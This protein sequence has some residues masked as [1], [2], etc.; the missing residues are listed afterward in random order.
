MPTMLR[1]ITLLLVLSLPTTKLVA[2]D[3]GFKIAK[4]GY[5]FSFPRDHGSHP[6]F[7]TEWWYYT[8]HLKTASGKDL[9][10]EV[11]FFRVGLR[12]EDAAAPQKSAWTMRNVSL[13]H[14]AITDIGKQKFRFYEK[15]NRSTPFTADSATGRLDV[16]NEQWNVRSQPDGS[17]RLIAAASGDSIDLNLRSLKPPAIHGENGISIKAEGIG[18]ASHYYSLTRMQVKGSVTTSGKPENVTG[19]AWMDHEFGS[20]VLRENQTGWDWFSLQ[21]NDGREL[22]LYIIRS[23]DGSPD[24]TSSGSLI[25]RD[26]K[27]RHLRRGEFL[28]S[29]TGKWKSAKS[30][31]TYP[32]GWTISVP[33]EQLQLTV[34]DRMKA[35]ELITTSSTQITYWEGAVSV[36]GTSRG[37]PLA[38][39]GYVEMTGYAE[40]FRMP[41]D[42]TSQRRTQP[43]R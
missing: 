10:F 38:G 17:H 1:L 35:Q 8:G 26:G 11:T 3:S 9:G 40:A 19:L 16:F 42:K 23:A 21:L 15:L 4:P 37:L 30:K 34:R 39:V 18:Y 33:S 43:S 24:V 29:A 7:R 36:S 31:A 20:A 28:V 12:S 13:A 32:M 27:V 25:E 6:D 2:Q 14:F 5:V 41:G 22:M